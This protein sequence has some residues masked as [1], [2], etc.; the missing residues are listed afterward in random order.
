VNVDFSNNHLTRIMSRG[1]YYH[2]VAAE[3]LDEPA[4]E[5]VELVGPLCMP[6]VL[7][8]GRTLP[9]LQRGDLVAALDAGMYAETTSSQFNGQPRPATVLVNGADAD[10]IKTRETT[11]D[12]FAHHRIPARLG[13]MDLRHRAA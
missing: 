4:T 3:K 13:G 7:G 9:P 5:S 10:I 1:D 6:D 11:E 12:V 2:F 8:A